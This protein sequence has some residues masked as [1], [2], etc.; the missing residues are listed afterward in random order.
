M[1]FQ[2][3]IDE[4]QPSQ[5]LIDGSKLADAAVWFD[6]DAPEYNPLS[7]R[8]FDGEL[9]LL[10]GHTRGLLAALAGAD[11]LRVE[12]DT[13]DDHERLYR[14]CVAWCREEEVTSV[15][16]LVGR[17]VSHETHETEWVERCHRAA[18]RL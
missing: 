10:D 14:E 7:V 17:V 1:T 11:E 16:D 18:E 9:V 8:E 3:P 6:F 2:V 5:L 15:R 4:P 13:D 12:R